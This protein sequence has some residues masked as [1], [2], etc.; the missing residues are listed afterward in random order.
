[1]STQT[2]A[3]TGVHPGTVATGDG[4]ATWS[5]YRR[6][7]GDP[8]DELYARLLPEIERIIAGAPATPRLRRH[9]SAAEQ[10]TIPPCVATDGNPSAPAPF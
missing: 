7:E 2:D 4:L 6:R 8:F 3:A 1:M 9:Q 5:P 10:I